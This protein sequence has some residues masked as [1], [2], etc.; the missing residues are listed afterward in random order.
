MKY[1]EKIELIK[2]ENGKKEFTKS[3]NGIKEQFV[4]LHFVHIHISLLLSIA[5]S[6]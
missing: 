1:N 3:K 6:F 4:T 2:S 5:Y